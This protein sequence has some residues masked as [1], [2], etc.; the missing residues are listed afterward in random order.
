MNRATA[1]VTTALRVTS[2]TC[3]KY[4]TS[5]FK[6]AA[7]SAPVKTWLHSANPLLQQR[8]LAYR[9][10]NTANPLELMQE[11]DEIVKEVQEEEIELPDKHD[12]KPEAV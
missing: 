11:Y 7:R 9:P 1:L 4:R 6:T 3:I 12:P 2:R 8:G 10:K 5:L